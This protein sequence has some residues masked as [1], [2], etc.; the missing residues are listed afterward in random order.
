VLEKNANGRRAGGWVNDYTAAQFLAVFADAGF[1]AVE[2][3]NWENQVIHRF[4]KR[5]AS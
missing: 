4:A 2:S 1:R 5:V 3:L